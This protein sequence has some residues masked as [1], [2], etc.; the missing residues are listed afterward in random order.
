M[1]NIG[2]IEN[3]P[4]LEQTFYHSYEPQGREFESLRAHLSEPYVGIFPS[5]IVQKTHI[6]WCGF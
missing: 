3:K 6:Y 4:V 5:N 1:V 2:N